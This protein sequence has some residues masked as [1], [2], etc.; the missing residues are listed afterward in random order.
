MRPA[1]VSPDGGDASFKTCVSP[2]G[3]DASFVRPVE[4]S[5]SVTDSTDQCGGLYDGVGWAPL[6]EKV[7]AK[8]S[9]AAEIEIQTLWRRP[10]RRNGL[11]CGHA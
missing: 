4:F 3:G 11:W 2:D 10:C 1:C 7:G 8:S 9:V 5:F 6:C